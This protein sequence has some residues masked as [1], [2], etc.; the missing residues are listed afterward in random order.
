[1]EEA[2]VKT[3]RMHIRLR[4][5]DDG[6]WLDSNSRLIF[7]SHDDWAE[8]TRMMLDFSYTGVKEMLNYTPLPT[9]TPLHAN[10]PSKASLDD[11]A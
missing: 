10:T 2:Q 5:V 9:R 8:L 3:E 6:V 11:L 7:F 4:R 1:M